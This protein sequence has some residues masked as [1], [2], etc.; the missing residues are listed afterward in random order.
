[1]QHKL[2]RAHGVLLSVQ[3]SNCNK[4]QDHNLEKAKALL[5]GLMPAIITGA[6]D[7]LRS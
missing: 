1:M 7:N 2:E 3:T 5:K 6:E 4:S